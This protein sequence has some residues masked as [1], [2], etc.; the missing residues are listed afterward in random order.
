MAGQVKCVSI[1]MQHI[2]F[3]NKAISTAIMRPL[4]SRN[5]A[6]AP[7]LPNGLYLATIGTKNLEE[8]YM[9]FYTRYWIALVSFQSES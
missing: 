1:L 7:G 3:K 9:Q 4:L 5:G 2:K 6:P 8:L